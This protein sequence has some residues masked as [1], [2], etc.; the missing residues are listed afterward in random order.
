MLEFLFTLPFITFMFLIKYLGSLLVW[1]GI[2]V[3]V[4]QKRDV[5]FDWFADRWFDIMY[6]FRNRKKSTKNDEK[7]EDYIV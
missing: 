6:W 4:Y 2:V 7:P 1:V 3:W 5:V